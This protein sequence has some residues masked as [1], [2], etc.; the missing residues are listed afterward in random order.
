LAETPAFLK[1]LLGALADDDRLRLDHRARDDGPVFG[2]NLSHS[3]LATDDAGVLIHD[4]LCL[5]LPPCEER[6]GAAL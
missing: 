4:E 2:E 5:L 1:I 6:A 3:E